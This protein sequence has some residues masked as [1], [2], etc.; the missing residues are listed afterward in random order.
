M[1]G[2]QERIWFKDPPGFFADDRLAH[3]LPMSNTTL[4]VQLNALM[5]LAIYAS[6]LMVLFRRYSLAIYVPAGVAALTYL[7]YVSVAVEGLG[8]GKG[9]GH[10]HGHTREGVPCTVPTPDNPFMNVLLHEYSG[11]PNR[12]AA[13]DLSTGGAAE[14]TDNLFQNNLFRDVD[15]V[16]NR[17]SSSHNFYAMPNTQIPNDQSGFA[18]WCYDTGPTFKEEGLEVWAPN[19]QGDSGGAGTGN[20]DGHNG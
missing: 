8:Q 2:G 12:R 11:D 16:F 4:A 15:D 13:C 1:P 3:F 17:R 5:R 10:G 9:Q 7:M 19:L 14:R 18:R 20:S 6:V